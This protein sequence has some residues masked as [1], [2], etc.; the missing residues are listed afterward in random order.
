MDARE[1]V[2]RS[3][4]APA[5][6]IAVEPSSP[7]PWA[8]C[9]SPT[10]SRAPG[11][12]T[13]RNSVLPA[14]S[15]GTSMLSP[16]GQGGSVG[17]PPAAAGG[18]AAAGASAAASSAR[19][20]T[21]SSGAGA[22]PIVP[23][24]GRAGTRMPGS[25]EV[26]AEP[27]PPS[28]QTSMTGASMRSPSSPSPGASELIAGPRGST[29]TISIASSMPGSAPAIATGPVSGWMRSTGNVST[30]AGVLAAWRWPSPESIVSSVNVSPGSTVSTGARCGYQRLW[31]TPACAASGSNGSNAHHA[32]HATIA[33]AGWRG[34]APARR[35]PVAASA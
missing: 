17:R 20:A 5:V 14:H 10:D 33:H 8:T 6:S 22:T 18:R 23:G 28:C 27:S 11:T 21:S 4:I 7:A 19:Q 3:V 12:E 31:P 25:D 32:G 16:V 13:G 9:R 29:S 15:A 1:R 34:S 2:Q 30:S 24:N 35:K 26:R